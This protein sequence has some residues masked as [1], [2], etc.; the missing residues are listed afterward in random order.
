MSL[1]DALF[2]IRRLT[3]N[4]GEVT[5]RQTVNLIGDAEV[6]DNPSEKRVDVTINE[7]ALAAAEAAQDAADAA[8]E[9]A[10]QALTDA[11]MAQDTANDA[12]AAANAAQDDV[13]ALTGVVSGISG[14][15]PFW[16]WNGV[17][18]SQFDPGLIVAANMSAGDQS[19]F[20]SVVADSNAPYGNVLRLSL[21]P[22]WPN[23]KHGVRLI[24]GSFPLRYRI[25]FECKEPVDA[26]QPYFGFV[27]FGQVVSGVLA[28]YA[29]AG[30]T[31]TGRWRYDPSGTISG[32]ETQNAGAWGNTT[33]QACDLRVLG[34][35]RTGVP[36]KFLHRSERLLFNSTAP[37][38]RHDRNANWSGEPAPASWNSLTNDRL[39]IVVRHNT[40]DSSLTW[41]ILSLRVYEI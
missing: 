36:V 29:I 39:G 21:S 20:L 28:G 35:K 33:D 17:D 30:G 14:G 31:A 12:L 24:T 23:L 6:V 7:G 22:T 18:L 25:E 3:S 13:D 10:T 26:V 15:A 37:V 8:Q 40:G 41:D 2:G 16:E 4:G 34:V 19:N 32:I 38:A 9:D 5:T 11:A 1:L 27:V